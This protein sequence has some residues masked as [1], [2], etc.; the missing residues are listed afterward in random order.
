MVALP[1]R[2]AIQ[3]ELQKIFG[4]YEDLEKMDAGKT[5][6]TIEGEVSLKY[7]ADIEYAAVVRDV[8]ETRV[9]LRGAYDEINAMYK[10]GAALEEK[11]SPTSK[12]R[13][14][15]LS[16]KY[17]ASIAR[18]RIQIPTGAESPCEIVSPSN[19]DL[20]GWFDIP[21]PDYSFAIEPEA[22]ERKIDL[23]LQQ[24][25]DG[26]ASIQESA[27]FREF[28]TTMS[29]FWQ[30]SIGNQIL[31]MLQRPSATHVAG[32]VA[33][34]ENFERQVKAGEKAIS[35]LAPC[36]PPKGLPEEIWRTS[37]GK[38]YLL[39]GKYVY[40]PVNGQKLVKPFETRALA[41]SW[42]KEQGAE[43]ESE[44]EMG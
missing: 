26:V 36:L 19:Y 2:E 39:R 5:P 20:L 33:W 41:M 17:R 25:K 10:E 6:T 13:R 32:Y 28:L 21:V 38:E 24:L 30:Y 14:G 15:S 23:V 29:K 40:E 37:S 1:N 31:I 16:D 7:M 12:I 27:V 43:K 22:K 3:A 8:E 9:L 44:R 11:L 42:L 18:R 4:S 34:K 35:I